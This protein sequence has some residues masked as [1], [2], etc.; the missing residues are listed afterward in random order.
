MTTT[1]TLR[2][3]TYRLWLAWKLPQTRGAAQQP[4]L[5]DSRTGC[6]LANLPAALQNRLL[7]SSRPCQTA[8]PAAAWQIC[9]PHCKTVCCA[10]AAPA[11]QQ[12]RLL[13]GKSACRTAKPFAAQQPPLPDSRTGCCLANPP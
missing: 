1:Y 9:L 10:A 12:N 11:R 6:C 5:P 7:R 3:T 4:P 8:E 13:P 2:C